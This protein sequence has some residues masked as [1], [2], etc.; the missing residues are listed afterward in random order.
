[1]QHCC[2]YLSMI[3]TAQRQTKTNTMYLS[4]WKIHLVVNGKSFYLSDI[5]ENTKENM[6]YNVSWCRRRRPYW[7]IGHHTNHCRT[8]EIKNEIIINIQLLDIICGSR[9][10]PHLDL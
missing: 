6:D 1:M 7:P 5:G 4:N 10:L 3:R 8:I 9:F 2:T